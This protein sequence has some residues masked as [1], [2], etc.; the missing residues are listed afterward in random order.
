MMVKWRHGKPKWKALMMFMDAIHVHVI[1][2]REQGK[3]GANTPPKTNGYLWAVHESWCCVKP[4][5]LNK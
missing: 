3:V 1:K 5:T 2:G 4:P